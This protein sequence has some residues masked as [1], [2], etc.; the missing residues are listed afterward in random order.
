MYQNR[1][2]HANVM[3]KVQWEAIELC[4]IFGGTRLFIRASGRF[5]GGQVVYREEGRASWCLDTFSPD[6]VDPCR[7]G[8][9]R[10]DPHGNDEM[11]IMR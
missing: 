11:N 5:K 10:L 2:P 8:F 1:M 7:Y 9:L 4:A 3:K 6:A